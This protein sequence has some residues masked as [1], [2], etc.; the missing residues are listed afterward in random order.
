MISLKI[1]EQQFDCCMLKLNRI[2]KSDIQYEA[3]S[4]IRIILEY[5]RNGGLCMNSILRDK[6]NELAS[7][8]LRCYEIT[9]PIT[10][11]AKEVE[12]LGGE[13]KEDCSL[14]VFSDGKIEKQGDSFSI[15]VPTNQSSARKN[16]TIAHEL[17]HLFLHMGYKIDK[18]LWESPENKVYNRSG[19]SEFELQANEFAAAFLMPKE[20]YKKVMDE[21]TVGNTVY[22]AKVAKFFNVSIDAASYR[23]KWL[24]YLQW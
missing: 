12:K 4:I 16:F 10:D 15:S 5:I 3:L 6:I 8:V 1:K 18:E 14:G 2:I 22:I 11:I 19:D 7:T 20:L 13:I 21:N 17:G 23:G 24:G 9:P